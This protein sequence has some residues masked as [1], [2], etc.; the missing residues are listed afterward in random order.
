MTADQGFKLHPEAARDITDIW[1]YIAEE[2]PLGPAN[3]K[4][5]LLSS[6]ATGTY[7]AF[8]T[9]W[10]ITASQIDPCPVWEVQLETNLKEYVRERDEKNHVGD[11]TGQTGMP[12]VNR[13]S[14]APE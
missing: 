7:R 6:F 1:G 11:W 13:L 5:A 3:D 14:S 8:R 2:N 12:P 9:V 4:P 10:R